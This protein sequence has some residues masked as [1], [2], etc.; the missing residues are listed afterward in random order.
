MKVKKSIIL[1]FLVTLP[2][3]WAAADTW[4][5]TVRFNTGPMFLN[6][7]SGL[8]GIELNW[9]HYLPDGKGGNIDL[10]IPL[11]LDVCFGWG[12]LSGVELALQSGI[13]WIAIGPSDKNGLFLDAKLGGSVFLWLQQFWSFNVKFDIGYQFIFPNSF[14]FTPALGLNYNTRTGIG[15]NVML[16]IGFAY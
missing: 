13:E 10:G 12:V 3:S 9:T 4:Q 2:L 14:L 16:D 7:R 15:V 1:L 6:M 5:G 8:P 11:E